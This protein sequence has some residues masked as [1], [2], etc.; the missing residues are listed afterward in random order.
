MAKVY[1]SLPRIPGQADTKN[2][3]LR[4]LKKIPIFFKKCFFFY[5]LSLTIA[6]VL[7]KRI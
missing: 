6:G 4:Y 5:N 7:I 3:V 2:G 1:F